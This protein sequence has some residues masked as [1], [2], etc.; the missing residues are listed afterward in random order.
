[1][2]LEDDKI[3][4]IKRATVI[5]DGGCPICSKTV[6]WMEEHE[7]D[8]S[9]EMLP[10]QSESLGK[11]FPSVERAACMR[12]MHVVLPDGVVLAGEEALPEIF[13]R[14]KRFHYASALFKLP[15]AKT[16][17]R[18]FYRW[19]AERRYHIADVLHI[20]MKERKRR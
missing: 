11:R 9:F 15:G 12:A 7:Q 3:Q 19:F 1:M 5:Y 17:S 2:K 10:C 4:A 20:G 16:L 18:A 14:L 8:G 6:A 13:K